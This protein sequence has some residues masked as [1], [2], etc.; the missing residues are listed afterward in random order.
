MSVVATTLI[1]GFLRGKSESGKPAF[2]FLFFNLRN[3]R[4]LRPKNQPLNLV[5][6]D[7]LAP[8][9]G[10]VFDEVLHQADAFAVLQDS[11]FYA[12]RAE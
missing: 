1:A 10:L 5:N 9:F 3:L 6:A 12:A 2:I 11:N 7:I 8:E 4:N